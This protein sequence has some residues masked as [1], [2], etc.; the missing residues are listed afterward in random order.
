V[1]VAQVS[2]SDTMGGAARA[3]YRIHHALLQHGVDSRMC[4]GQANRG[5]WTVQTI[6][7]R[8]NKTINKFRHP[9]AR[10]VVRA[11]GTKNGARQSP[12]IFPSHWQQQLNDSD[13][14]VIHL[15]L[16]AEE[17]MSIAE[18]GR[19]QGPV[20]WTL[21]DMWGFCGAEHHTEE[22]RWRDGYTRRNRPD[23]ESGFDLN[24]WTW[25]RKRKYW[26]RPFQIA[27]PSHWLAECVQ[28]SVLMRDWPVSVVPNPIDTDVW[29]PIDKELA[30]SI[31]RLP[32]GAPLLLFGA[33]GGTRD[34][35]KGFNLLRSAVS[36]L[37]GKLAGLELVVIGQLAPKEPLDLNFPVHYAGHQYDNASLRLYYSAAS[38]VVVPSRLDNLP[39]CA[40]EAHACGTPVVAF[41]AGG[42][43][44]IVD[45]EKTGYLAK[46][47][48]AE[49][50]ARGIQ[51][52]LEDAERCAL[53]GT[54]S[55]RAAVARYSYPVVAEQYLQVY[56]AAIYA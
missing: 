3:A 19:L 46:P 16:M 1:K 36:H 54:R 53:L 35:R 11:I 20:V 5:D 12:N 21:H 33:D 30:R 23:Y 41:H 26:H 8:W 47:Y 37:E 17:M 40:V 44:D 39:N 51:W 13:V 56:K 18:I 45:H 38:A 52:V 48:D 32:S 14:D 50:L 25:Q 27:A 6:H 4:V 55:R 43:P 22:V 7:G 34:P 24:R 42:L 49:D 28:Q 29:A 15:H 2:Y 31:L 10:L 9:V